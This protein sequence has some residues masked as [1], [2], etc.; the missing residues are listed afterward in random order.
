MTYIEVAMKEE[1]ASVT[2]E[3]RGFLVSNFQVK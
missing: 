1:E 2:A 3:F